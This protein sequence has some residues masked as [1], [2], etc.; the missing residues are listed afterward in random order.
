MLVT[1]QRLQKNQTKPASESLE[2]YFKV[3]LRNNYKTVRLLGRKYK[4]SKLLHSSVF[5][6]A[7]LLR[8][9]TSGYKISRRLKVSINIHTVSVILQYEHHLLLQRLQGAEQGRLDLAV[10]VLMVN[11]SSSH[12]KD[13]LIVELAEFQGRLD[14]ALFGLIS[15]FFCT[16]TEQGT[17]QKK[18]QEAYVMMGIHILG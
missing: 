13:I 5:L 10:M 7:G 6:G 8:V 11:L 2:N 16:R 15:V 1:G 17:K 14:V 9:R 18:I 12:R 4:G 3:T